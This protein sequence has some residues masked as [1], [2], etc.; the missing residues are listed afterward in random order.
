MAGEYST[1]LSRNRLNIVSPSLDYE[2]HRNYTPDVMTYAGLTLAVGGADGQ[3]KAIGRIQSFQRDAMTRTLTQKRE[4]NKDTFGRPIETIPGV[5]DG[6]TMTMER[7]EILGA[8][9]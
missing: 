5:A 1:S 7:L 8:G 2:N 6:Y 4:L 9:V 3:Y